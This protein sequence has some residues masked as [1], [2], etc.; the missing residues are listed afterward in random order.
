MNL[1]DPEERSVAA[2]EY[3]LGTLDAAARAELEA[4]LP[5]DAALRAEV[6]AWQDRLLPLATRG[7]AAEPDAS[8][9]PRIAERIARPAPSAPPSP[10]PAA[11]SATP[12]ANDALWRSQRRWRATALLSMA[13]TVALAA[14]LVLRPPETQVR[15]ITLLQAPETQR[16]GWVVEATSGERIRLVPIEAGAAVPAGKSLQFWTKP[17]G[18]DRPTSLGLVQ[19][20]TRL[21]LPV[22]RS[23]GLGAE[24]LFEL[25]LEPQG[26]SPTGLPTGPIL[27]VGRSV[28][29]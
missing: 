27:F 24:Q 8:L 11:Q 3:V 21:E 23:P 2:A 18:A 28:R 20:G 16:T 6:Y 7:P 1:Q 26:G 17:Q 9:W 19:P 29:L 25:T 12:A 10:M 14:V 22:E 5:S 4:L 13:A 15:Y